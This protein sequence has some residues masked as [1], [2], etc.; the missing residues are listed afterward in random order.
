MTLVID[1]THWLDEQ[2]Q[3]PRTNLRLRRHALRIARFIEYGGPLPALQARETL[4]ECKRRP[5]HRQCLGL[6]WVMKRN[7]DRIEVTCRDCQDIEA[8]ISGWQGTDWAEGV[9]PGMPMTDD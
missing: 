8:V 4:V 5:A 7:D 9:M 6:L 3:I 1:I 2:G